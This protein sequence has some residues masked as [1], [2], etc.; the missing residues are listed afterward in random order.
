MRQADNTTI[1]PIEVGVVGRAHALVEAERAPLQDLVDAVH[2]NQAIGHARR[3]T[4]SG[5]AQSTDREQQTDADLCSVRHDGHLVE[6]GLA[7]EEHHVVV[8]E[9]TLH[10]VAVTQVPSDLLAVGVLR[11]A[12]EDGTIINTRSNPQS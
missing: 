11:A 8:V 4:Q 1:V 9:V 7:V 5:V 10:Q 12:E 6:R 2:E 3:N